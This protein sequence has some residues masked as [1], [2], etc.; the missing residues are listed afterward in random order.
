[1]ASVAEISP[2]N[3]EFDTPS[4]G[5]SVGLKKAIEEIAQ[6]IFQRTKISLEGS[7]RAVMPSIPVMLSEIAD[8][9]REGS[10]DK[11]K[12]SLEKLEKITGKLG[13]D[14]SKYN[15]ELAKFLKDREENTIK[16]EQKIVETREKGAKAEI[17]QITGKINVLS[18]EEIKQRTDTL[19]QTLVSQTGFEQVR[20]RND[21][22]NKKIKELH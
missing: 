22:V 17:D 7:A 1:M 2:L 8:D 9:I 10:V 15:K 5:V 14:L 4:K 11:F 19:K 18:R 20:S 21:I 6:V 3:T 13:V 16:S 12:I